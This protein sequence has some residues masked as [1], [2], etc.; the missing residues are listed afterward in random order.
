[1]PGTTHLAPS[2]SS[3]SGDIRADQLYHLVELQ[4]DSKGILA[5]LWRNSPKIGLLPPRL[6]EFARDHSIFL[7]T[8]FEQ[9][10]VES[11]QAPDFDLVLDLNTALPVLSNNKDP[12]PSLWILVRLRSASIVAAQS[13][14]SRLTSEI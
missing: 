9:L 1:M 7:D 5:A 4:G 6:G 10:R 11:A 12:Q 13:P 8:T 2:T 3:P 14:D